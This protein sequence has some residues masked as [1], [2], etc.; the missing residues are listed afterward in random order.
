MSNFIFTKCKNSLLTGSINFSS[1]SIKVLAVN[2]NYNP[3]QDEDEFVSD[4]EPSSIV[5]RSNSL[6]GKTISQ[7]RLDANDLQ[8]DNYNGSAIDAIVMYVDSGND[9]TSR[10]ISYIDT[11]TGLP[12]EGVNAQ[13]GVTI[14]WNDNSTKIISL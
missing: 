3:S 11:S 8:I 1:N 4:I 2:S 10:L 9:S 13:A 6:S 5:F 14:I 7:G 12:F